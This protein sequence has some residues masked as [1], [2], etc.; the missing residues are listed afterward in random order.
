MDLLNIKS[1]A[2]GFSAEGCNHTS[3]PKSDI[4]RLM[5]WRMSLSEDLAMKAYFLE[6][7]EVK[8]N[9]LQPWY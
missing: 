1:L 5:Q 8:L 3:I 6:G 7:V 9:A 4:R 2:T